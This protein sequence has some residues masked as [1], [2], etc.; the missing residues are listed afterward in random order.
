MHWLSILSP[1]F[2]SPFLFF[3][4][5]LL[6][7]FCASNFW[8]SLNG[9]PFF[10]LVVTFYLS[11][12]SSVPFYVVAIMGFLEDIVFGTPLGLNM[13]WYSFFFVVLKKLRPYF[14]VNGF[15]L[16]M[17]FFVYTLV[18]IGWNILFFC[19]Q[20][21]VFVSPSVLLPSFFYTIFLFPFLVRG[22]QFYGR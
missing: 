5:I 12:Y 10:G 19:F 2:Y 6:T 14:K 16:W 7:G 3:A 9:H 13:F 1:R 15:V 18:Y 20:G 11:I 4:Y 22:L 21:V 8:I 17:E